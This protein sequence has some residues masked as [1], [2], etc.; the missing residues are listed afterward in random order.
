MSS[1]KSEKIMKCLIENKKSLNEEWNFGLLGATKIGEYYRTIEMLVE[2]IGKTEKEVMLI[3][4]FYMIV[5]M[6][7]KI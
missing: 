4:Y 7:V 5:H 6:M 2:M 3:L 1:N